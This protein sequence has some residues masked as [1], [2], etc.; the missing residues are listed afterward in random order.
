MEARL[1]NHHPRVQP[2]LVRGID[3]VTT[4]QYIIIIVIIIIATNKVYGFLIISVNLLQLQLNPSERVLLIKVHGIHITT[5]KNVDSQK[6]GG[7]GASSL[8]AI[9]PIIVLT[10]ALVSHDSILIF[11]VFLLTVLVSRYP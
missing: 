6:R 9:K 5:S 2:D 7:R 3:V 8:G 4:V 11:R 1:S 10:A